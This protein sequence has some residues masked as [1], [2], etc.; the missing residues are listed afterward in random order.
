MI[1]GP[2]VLCE[3]RLIV[4]QATWGPAECATVV[5]HPSLGLPE[6]CPLSESPSPLKVFP[7]MH[8]GTLY[9]SSI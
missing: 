7:H 3:P 6:R 4:V 9:R 2:T 5:A 8:A 1:E